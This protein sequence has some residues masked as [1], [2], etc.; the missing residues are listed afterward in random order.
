ML[1]NK[2]VNH[3]IYPPPEDD[4]NVQYK[5]QIR[6]TPVAPSDLP[7]HYEVTTVPVGGT[8]AV[9]NTLEEGVVVHGVAAP[10]DYEVI[11]V[12]RHNTNCHRS[13]HKTLNLTHK[14]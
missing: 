6:A 10:E 13:T 7:L 8:S 12:F 3:P 14:I 2:D 1:Y 9:Q 4:P 11:N 5:V